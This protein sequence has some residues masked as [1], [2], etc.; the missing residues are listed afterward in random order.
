MSPASYRAA[1]PRVGASTVRHPRGAG[2][3]LCRSLKGIGTSVRTASG[4][5]D[6]AA[7]V[8]DDD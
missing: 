7:P 3:D 2:R 6:V 1:P 8:K 5:Q 4:R